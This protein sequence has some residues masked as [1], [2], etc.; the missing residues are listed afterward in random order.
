MLGFEIWKNGKKLATAGLTDSGAISLML[1]WVGKGPGASSRIAEGVEIEGLDL[2]VGGIDAAD[3]MSEQSV[4]WIEDNALRLGDD[5]QIKLVSTPELDA[6][7]RR[8]PT[9]GLA[10]AAAGL[11]FVPCT[12]CGAPRLQTGL[13]HTPE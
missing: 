11:R 10:S 6:P 3:P 5:I 4:E 13:A 2:R 12:T 8:E 9:D 1:T 7:V